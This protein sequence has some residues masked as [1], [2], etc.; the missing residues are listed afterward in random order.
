MHPMQELHDLA[1]LL[2]LMLCDEEHEAQ[3]ER[4]F[5]T[6]NCAFYILESFEDCW[7]EDDRA[8]WLTLARKVRNLR[9]EE[10]VQTVA[11]HVQDFFKV[12]VLA[13][14]IHK[15]LAEELYERKD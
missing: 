7:D 9:P 13:P 12:Y 2:H 11:Q 4:A 15:M 14:K 6:S 8:R 5:D 1:S 3:M 10:S